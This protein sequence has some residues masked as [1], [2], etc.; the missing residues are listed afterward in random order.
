MPLPFASTK[1]EKALSSQEFI[2]IESI[3]DGIIVLK[4]SEG[5]RAVLMVSSL[6]FALKSEAEQDA[7]VFQYENFLNSLD[8]PLQLTVQSRRLNIHP[9]L[10]TLGQRQGEETND[11][12]KIQIGE[13]ME[14]VKTFV[15]M[16]HIVSKTFFAVVPFQPSV[17]RWPNARELSKICPCSWVAQTKRGLAPAPKM[18]LISLKTS[19]CKGWTR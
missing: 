14:F 18:S 16:S 9:Y 10:E 1:A 8:F 3:R 7:L 11:L 5:L 2:A 4:K 17:A 15:E 12:L 19:S 13:Y 6:N